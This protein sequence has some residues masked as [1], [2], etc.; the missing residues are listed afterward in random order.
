MA[1][2]KSLKAAFDQMAQRVQADLASLRTQL[3]QAQSGS[4]ISAEDQ[5]TLDQLEQTANAL[6]PNDSTTLGDV[7]TDQ[8]PPASSAPTT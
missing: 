7:G 4:K 3:A 8:T 6:D 2:V 5:A 1:D